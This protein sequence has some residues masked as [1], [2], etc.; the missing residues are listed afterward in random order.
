[1]TTNKFNAVVC[2]NTT[3]TFIGT[4][5]ADARSKRLVVNA[6]KSGTYD[7]VAVELCE[8]RLTRHQLNNINP[9]T[10]RS[11]WKSVGFNGALFSQGLSKFYKVLHDHHKID[12]GGEMFGVV[13]TAEKANIPYNLIDRDYRDS[14]R[15]IGGEMS[16]VRAIIMSAMLRLAGMSMKHLSREDVI[17]LINNHDSSQTLENNSVLSRIKTSLRDDR[18][19]YMVTSLKQMTHH[20]NVL[21]VV[22]VGHVDGMVALLNAAKWDCKNT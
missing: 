4:N 20:T 8:E 14:L 12:V 11:M 21:V 3:F 13:E 7:A 18:D 5:H 17:E 15:A 6:I 10:F 1:M 9:P 22:G 19:H 16:W 2:G